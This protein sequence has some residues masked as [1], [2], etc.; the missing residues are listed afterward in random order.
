MNQMYT[1]IKHH[2][3]TDAINKTVYLFDYDGTLSDGT[4]R[5]HKLPTKDLHL[6]ESWSEFNRLS[7]YDQP[8]ESTI[9]VMNSLY[10]SGAFIIILTG[11]SDE[12]CEISTQWLHDAGAKYNVM[13]M[14]QADDNR[15]DTIIKEEF[16]RYI[17]LH[18]ITAA[19][20]DSPSVVA[21]F[22]SLGITTYQV[23]DYG[24][25]AHSGLKS[26][27]VEKVCEHEFSDPLPPHGVRQCK[28]CNLVSGK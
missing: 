13:V 18:R 26:H 8:I 10:N 14:R 5:L 23:C 3:N 9:Q 1:M 25:N 12:V 15:K 16:L 7:E 28:K 2:L 24:D 17:G 27:G 19:F 4:H 22:R 6:T 21:H 20:D 11:R